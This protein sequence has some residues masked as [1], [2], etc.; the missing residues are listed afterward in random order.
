MIIAI[1]NAFMLSDI[2]MLHRRLEEQ[3]LW[4]KHE[5]QYS[6]WNVCGGV[7]V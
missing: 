2:F 5:V 7:G 3:Q 4:D 6:Q 1:N